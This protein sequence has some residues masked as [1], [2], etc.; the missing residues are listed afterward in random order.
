MEP[1]RA[2]APAHLTPALDP[3]RNAVVEACAGSGKTWL[4]VS[5]ML[6][7]MLAGAAPSELLAITFTRKAAEEMR[8]RLD[9]WLQDLALLP[10]DE[11]MAFLIQRG[12]SEVEART[13]LPRA[14]SLLEFVLTASPGPLITTFH[15]WFFHLL[16]H[17]PLSQRVA[18]ELLE[19][20]ALL[21]EEAWFDFTQGLGRSPDTPEALA[22][23]ALGSPDSP[24][25]CS[26]SLAS[27]SALAAS[28]LRISA[29]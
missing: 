26:K 5:R 1:G 2:A 13:A 16:D 24:R 21:N 18:G 20:P 14:R 29:I 9:E 28:F 11:A 8:T 6:R 22:F 3:A 25:N 23:K 27:A 17:A 4:L 15:G 12:M 10:E 7:L 19:H